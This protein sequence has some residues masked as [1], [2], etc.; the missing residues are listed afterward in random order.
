M[1]P[2]LIH[3]EAVPKEARDAL[4]AASSAPPERRRAE[5]E[6]A[7]RVLYRE[8]ELDCADARELV[9][10]APGENCH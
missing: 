8:T 5:L 7:A 3:S 9:G 10:L 6:R 2:L 1:A 4:K